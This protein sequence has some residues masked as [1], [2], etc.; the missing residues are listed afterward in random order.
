MKPPAASKIMK[1]PDS[2]YDELRCIFRGKFSFAKLIMLRELAK[3]TV[4]ESNLL[5]V[6]NYVISAKNAQTW[7]ISIIFFSVL[8]TI[9]QI[10]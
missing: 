5:S 8:Y 7:I 6:L 1:I 2:G 10:T 3:N 4:G 9:P